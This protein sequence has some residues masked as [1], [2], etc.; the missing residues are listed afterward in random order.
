MDL[1]K[2]Q[3]RA[4]RQGRGD[5]VILAITQI[6]K[7][8]TYRPLE[9]GELLYHLPALRLEI[10]QGAV[11]PLWVCYGVSDDEPL[12]FIKRIDLLP[13]RNV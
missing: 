13:S 12:V 6:W 11:I 7:R 2:I 5:Q 4:S 3:R 8:L 10:R 9:F 1:H